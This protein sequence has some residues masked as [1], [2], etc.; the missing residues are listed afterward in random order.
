MWECAGL[1]LSVKF[2]LSRTSRTAVVVN[3][4]GASNSAVRDAAVITVDT[5]AFRR[6][7]PTEVIAYCLC[8]DRFDCQRTQQYGQSHHT[9]EQTKAGQSRSDLLHGIS[10]YAGLGDRGE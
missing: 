8:A 4:L 5:A 3:F 7:T 6:P 9:R 10:S 1:L 2:G